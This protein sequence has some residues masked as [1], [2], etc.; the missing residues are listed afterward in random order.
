[1]TL[2]LFVVLYVPL[3][4]AWRLERHLKA[5]F[6]VTVTQ[7]AR[8]SSGG[9]SPVAS[10]AGGSSSKAAVSTGCASKCGDAGDGSGNS[11]SRVACSKYISPG[12]SFPL[13][14]TAKG[15]LASHLG[16]AAAACFLLGELFVWVCTVSPA[17]AGI[18]WQQIPYQ[19]G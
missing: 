12:P 3:L 17:L 10:S 7:N 4:F 18:L 11:S 14:P 6:M 2:M 9:S 8:T 5:R 13:F 19:A 16:A 1:M 15:A